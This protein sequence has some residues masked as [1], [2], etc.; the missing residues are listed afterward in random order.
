[1]AANLISVSELLKVVHGTKCVEISGNGVNYIMSTFMIPAFLLV[2][3]HNVNRIYEGHD[4]YVGRKKF[5][6]RANVW[7]GS[8]I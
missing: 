5:E 4:T 7:R 2:E 3:H 1:M 6:T 8:L